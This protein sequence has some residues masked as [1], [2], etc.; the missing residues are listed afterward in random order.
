MEVKRG[1]AFGDMDGDKAKRVVLRNRS[2]L[3]QSVGASAQR[4]L[5]PGGHPDRD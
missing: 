2:P 4:R 3:S 5:L 1:E